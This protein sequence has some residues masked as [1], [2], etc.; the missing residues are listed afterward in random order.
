MAT[1]GGEGGGGDLQGLGHGGGGSTGTWGG[2][3]SAGGGRTAAAGVCR[4]ALFGV[5]FFN[6]RASRWEAWAAAPGGGSAAAAVK[7]TRP[8]RRGGGQG[9]SRT[10][11]RRLRPWLGM[12]ALETTTDGSA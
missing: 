3:R 5:R 10:E 12:R 9:A 6:A 8:R 7:A 2:A 11:A 1:R 4:R